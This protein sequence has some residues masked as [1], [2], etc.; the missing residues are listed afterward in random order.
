MAYKLGRL[1]P[2]IH[3]NTLKFSNYLL[4]NSALPVPPEKAYWEFRVPDWKMLANDQLGDCVLAAF[5]HMVMNWTAH[6]GDESIPTDA[7]I[8]EAYSAITGYD[9]SKTNQFGDNPTDNGTSMTDGYAYWQNKG[10]AGHKIDGWVSIDWNN[11]EHVKLAVYLFG[12]VNPGVNLPQSAMDQF[13]ANMP[14]DEVAGSPI[15]GGHSIPV[16]GYG[17]QGC[18][19]V[20]WAKRQ[21]MSWDFFQKQSEELYAAVSL[22]WVDK[23]G[24]APSHINL[25]ALRSDL[26]AIKI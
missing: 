8:I 20:S 3:P 6:E 1:A 21:P 18:T 25:D 13:D 16:F 10:V 14:W 12:G 7:Q 4:K 26:L 15:I 17:S 11:I 2:K 5:G 22:D 9:P 24:I 19:C 23:Q